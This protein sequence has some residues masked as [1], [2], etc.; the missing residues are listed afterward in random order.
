MYGHH[1]ESLKIMEQ[2][3]REKEEVIA[4]VFGGSVAKGTERPEMSR[5]AIA[6]A[7]FQV[8]PEGRYW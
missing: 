1:E 4:L 8:T 3:F 5:E 7:S 2:M 6:W